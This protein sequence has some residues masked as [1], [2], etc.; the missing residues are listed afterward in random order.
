MHSPRAH[1][2]DGGRPGPPI[3][4]LTQ[5]D[6]APSSNANFLP[7]CRVRQGRRRAIRVQEAPPAASAPF[8]QRLDPINPPASENAVKSSN[9]PFSDPPSPTVSR[10]PFAPTPRRWTLLALLLERPV[11]HRLT[12]GCVEPS[13]RS[14][15]ATASWLRGKH[16]LAIYQQPSIDRISA[17][18]FAQVVNRWI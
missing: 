16:V 12:F 8:V 11:Y 18:F 13:L 2:T 1:R 9:P 10:V 15:P 7:Q 6:F 3:P 14:A 4:E 17:H 5:C